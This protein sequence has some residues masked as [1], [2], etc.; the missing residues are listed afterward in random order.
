MDT[1]HA[2]MR[3]QDHRD[4]NRELLKI[5]KTKRPEKAVMIEV[6]NAT[7]QQHLLKLFYPRP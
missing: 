3:R 1:I 7:Q 4:A 6:L 2:A 5:L